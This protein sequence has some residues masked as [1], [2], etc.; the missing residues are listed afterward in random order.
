MLVMAIYIYK[1]YII[2]YIITYIYL[3]ILHEH[4]H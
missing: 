3:F 1:I 2:L 4:N